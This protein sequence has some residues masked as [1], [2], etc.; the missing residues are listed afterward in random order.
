MLGVVCH[1]V[2]CCQM[3]KAHLR[4]RWVGERVP[5]THRLRIND[6]R[7]HY[8]AANQEEGVALLQLRDYSDEAVGPGFRPIPAKAAKRA[9]TKLLPGSCA[10]IE[11]VPGSPGESRQQSAEGQ[12]GRLSNPVPVSCC[13]ASS[14]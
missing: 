9:R 4:I 12:R 5:P 7:L 10:V 13:G 2:C 1:R 14:C 6:P 3:H 8:A 11:P